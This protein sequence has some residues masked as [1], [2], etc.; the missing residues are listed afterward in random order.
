MKILIKNG[1]IIDGTNNPGFLGSIIINNDKIQRVEKENINYGNFDQIIDVQ[2]LVVA[3]GFIDAHSHSDVELLK[4]PYI[5]PKLKQGITTE[6]LGQDGISVAPL[7]SK[8]ITTWRKNISGLNGDGDTIDWNFPTVESYFQSLKNSGIGTNIGYLLPHGNIRMEAMGLNN[9]APTRFELE[10]MKKIIEREMDA[11][12]LGLSTGL[13]YSPCMYS[14]LQ[15]L[16]ECCKIVKEYNGVFVAHQRS[17]ADNILKSLDEIIQIG[18]QTGVNIHLSHMKICGRN[19]W[20]K[21]NDI[22]KKL[23]QAHQN[24]INISFD[25]YPYTAGCT[26]LSVVLPPWVHEGGSDMLLKRLGCKLVREK[27]IKDI[28]SGIPG[29]DN[30]INFA[31][32][33][34]IFITN[35]KIS[36]NQS[37][38]GKS[39]IEI[40]E[41]RKQ[42]PMHAM[43]DLL[44]EEEN[45]VGMVDFYGTEENVIAFMQRKEQVFCTDGIYSTFPHPRTYSAFPRVLGRYVREKRVLP[46]E[47]AIHKMTY[48]TAQIYGLK[49]QGVLSVGKKANI[50]VFNQNTIKDTNSFLNPHKFPQGIHHLFINGKLVLENDDFKKIPAGEIIKNP[51]VQ[52]ISEL[53]NC[54]VF[55]A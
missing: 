11:G 27:I 55:A 52:Q 44:I 47:E 26:T 5:L 36:Q 54:K 14:N 49:D 19:N 30:F 31:G 9:V 10:A 17:E 18:E 16:I 38:I 42:D 50:I 41:L 37:L 51:C 22:F 15:E 45:S 13:I 40:G 24:G 39:L 23:D 29:W 35:A 3:P 20:N 33:D 46:I 1:N 2:G 12:A 53:N 21:I 32:M 28:N 8:Y 7:P 6:I 34:K 4:A 25:L 48:R 43:F